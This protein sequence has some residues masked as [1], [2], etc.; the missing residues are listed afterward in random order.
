MT[1]RASIYLALALVLAFVLGTLAYKSLSHLAPWLAREERPFR[2]PAGFAVVEIESTAD[3]SRQKAIFRPARGPR[4]PLLVSLHVWAG[5]YESADPLASYVDKE[6]WNYIHPDFRGPNRGPD[7]C[8]SDKVIA[9][10]DDAIAYGLGAGH[11]NPEQVFVV[12]FSGGAYAAIGMYARTR[13][14]VH[15]FSVWSPIS[16]VGAWHDELMMRGDVEVAQQVRQCTG[17]G[18]T[19][20]SEEARSRSPLYWMLPEVPKA[21]IEI[22]AGIDDGYTGPV[23]ISHSIRFFNRLAQTYGAPNQLLTTGEISVLLSRGL[24][25]S[26]DTREVGGRPLLFQRSAP[27]GSL[28]IFQGGHEMLPMLCFARLQ[29]LAAGA[30]TTRGPT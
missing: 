25:A 9:D 13:H 17:G 29:S 20:N 10:I 27:F 5:D 3:H 12:G 6:D 18:E 2:W 8:L 22:F 14:R 21:R 19:L 28:T 30:P 15:A 7:N 4:R 11:V 16:D 24:R 23:P 26:Q 1:R